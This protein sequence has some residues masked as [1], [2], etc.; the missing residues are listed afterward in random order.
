MLPALLAPWVF[1][2]SV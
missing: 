1:F 2:T